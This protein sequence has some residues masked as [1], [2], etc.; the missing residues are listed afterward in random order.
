VCPTHSLAKDPAV[1]RHFV[2]LVGFCFSAALLACGGKID[3]STDGATENR[4]GGDANNAASQNQFAGPGGNNNSSGPGSATG[5]QLPSS[6]SGGLTGDGD[7]SSTSYATD[8][9]WGTWQLL[10][11][12]TPSGKNYAPPFVEVELQPTGRA[13][14]WTCVKATTGDGERCPFELRREC[15]VG[16]GTLEGVVWHVKLNGKD[17]SSIGTAIVED[18]AS[19]DITL[20]GAGL[21]DAHAHYHR[22]AAAGNGCIPDP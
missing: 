8:G 16:T 18:D 4:S 10:S 11:I 21:L 1:M 13:Y 5:T 15:T 12:D 2:S 22:V 19:G 6:S 14:R 20:N 7:G 17:G 9:A 3:A